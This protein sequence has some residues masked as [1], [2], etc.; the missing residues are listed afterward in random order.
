MLTEHGC[1]GCAHPPLVGRQAYRV[2]SILGTGSA[3][4]VRLAAQRPRAR[5]VRAAARR[6]IGVGH[7]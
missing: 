4:R 6:V 7:E 1:P 5:D 2:E 3:F